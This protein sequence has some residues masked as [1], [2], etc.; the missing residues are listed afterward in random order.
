MHVS[1]C[2]MQGSIDQAEAL[3]SEGNALYAAGNLQEALVRQN[4]DPASRFLDQPI[5]VTKLPKG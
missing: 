3:K 2:V 4:C 1:L 5:E